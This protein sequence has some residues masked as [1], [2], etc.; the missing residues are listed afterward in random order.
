MPMPPPQGK[1]NTSDSLR[2][3]DTVRCDECGKR[4]RLL[5]RRDNARQTCSDCTPQEDQF[6]QVVEGD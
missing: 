6:A 4:V 5:F 1:V 2:H 3:S